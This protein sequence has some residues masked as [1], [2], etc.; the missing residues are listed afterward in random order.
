M[1]AK[2]G[3]EGVEGVKDTLKIVSFV[4]MKNI[5]NHLKTISR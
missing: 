4:G 1:Y 3:V 2:Q 5:A